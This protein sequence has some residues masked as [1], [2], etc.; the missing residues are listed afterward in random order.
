MS[1]LTSI[2]PLRVFGAALTNCLTLLL[3]KPRC[4]RLEVQFLLSDF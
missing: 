4:E 2:S 3:T 1:G